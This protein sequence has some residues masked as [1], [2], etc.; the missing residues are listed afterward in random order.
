MLKMP[1]IK[2]FNKCKYRGN[3]HDKE[4]NVTPAGTPRPKPNSPKKSSSSKKINNTKLPQC[5][6]D[7][8][9]NLNFIVGIEEI[10]KLVKSFTACRYCGS[11]D[12]VEVSLD[13]DFKCVLVHRII[14]SCNIFHMKNNAMSSKCIHNIYELNLRYVNA[15]HSIGKG[16]ESGEMFSAVMNIA[17]PNSRPEKYISRLLKAVKEVVNTSLRN[18]A[19]EAH[20]INENFGDI[21]AAFD[22]TWQ[23]RGHTS[24]N[25]VVT[26]TSFDTSNVLDFKCLSKYCNMCV[27]K[28]LSTNEELLR[29]HK[30]SGACLA[31]YTGASGGMEMVGAMKICSR[32]KTKLQLRYTQYLGDG[33]SKGFAHVLE[34]NPYGEDV[35]ISKL[36]CV[37]QIQKR[38]GTRLRTLKKIKKAFS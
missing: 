14:I 4:K 21:A 1:R 5:T 32:S 34:N 23:K 15:L 16:L 12:F 33:D 2:K 38:L 8:K 18:S 6:E 30:E 36:E 9:N 19:G 11:T 31:N 20:E 3:Q 26:T 29:Q 27:R 37:G 10:S 28:P 24:I 25:G 17:Q 7:N 22:G 13:Y 35:S